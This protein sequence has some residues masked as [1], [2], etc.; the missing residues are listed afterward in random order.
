MPKLVG[1]FV[2]DLNDVTTDLITRVRMLRETTPEDELA[3]MMPNELYK[4]AMECKLRGAIGGG[5]SILQ[6]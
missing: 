3:K 5:Q 6:C 4:W 2:T 1:D